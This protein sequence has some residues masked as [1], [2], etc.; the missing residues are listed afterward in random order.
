MFVDV[1]RCGGPRSR[2]GRRATAIAQDR[3]GRRW[4][5]RIFR[6]WPVCRFDAELSQ[7]AFGIG[8]DE[9]IR[10]I[11]P[12]CERA[13]LVAGCAFLIVSSA[14]ITG[15]RP[16]TLDSRIKARLKMS[17]ASGSGS[18]ERCTLP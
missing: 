13:E 1:V 2:L 17:A 4:P 10:R 11:A 12:E 6:L 3:P 16:D 14:I 18:G 8:V 5:G 7:R 15:P 9:A